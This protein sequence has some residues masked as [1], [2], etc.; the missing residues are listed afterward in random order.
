MKCPKCG[1]EALFIKDYEKHY[2]SNCKEYLAEEQPAET[3]EESV[4]P[5][6]YF[7]NSGTKSRKISNLLLP[8]GILAG[9]II[10]AIIFLPPFLL[11]EEDEYDETYYWDRANATVNYSYCDLIIV[12]ETKS[13]CY[14]MIAFKKNDPLICELLPVNKEKCYAVA[15]SYFKNDSWCELLDSTNLMEYCYQKVGRH[16]GES[17]CEKIIVSMDK[18]DLCYFEFAVELLNSSYCEEI[19]GDYRDTC[20]SEIAVE[21]KDES[22]CERINIYLYRDECYKRLAEEL[23]DETLCEKIIDAQTKTACNLIF[24]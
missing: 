11:M 3:K 9:V 13:F 20:Y 21:T 18:K 5:E 23:L 10:I 24:S 16:T 19:R 14:G 2:C 1:R 15:G 7:K 4:K 6:E 17:T 12:S 22:H 8:A